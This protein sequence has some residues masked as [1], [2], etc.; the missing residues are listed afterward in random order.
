MAGLISFCSGVKHLRL[1]ANVVK[2]R[3]LG[4]VS[5]RVLGEG[6]ERTIFFFINRNCS[7]LY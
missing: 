5:E 7:K 1:V 6:D 2:G 3:P 4:Q